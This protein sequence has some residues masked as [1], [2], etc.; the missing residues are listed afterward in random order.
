MKLVKRDVQHARSLLTV[1]GRVAPGQAGGVITWWSGVGRPGWGRMQR[2]EGVDRSAWC[3]S[4]WF[5]LNDWS[6]GQVMVEGA[7]LKI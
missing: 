3:Q 7:Q 5:G 6:D 2:S 4:C 1:A